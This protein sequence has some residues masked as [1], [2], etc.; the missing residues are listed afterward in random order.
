MIECGFIFR[1]KA[2]APLYSLCSPVA[3][4]TVNK[5]IFSWHGF[6]GYDVSLSNIS[7]V[8]RETFGSDLK[9]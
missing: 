4:A 8:L 6:P 7:E 9:E 1:Q 5:F 2:A 3:Q